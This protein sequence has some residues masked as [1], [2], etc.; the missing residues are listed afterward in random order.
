MLSPL[1]PALVT[2]L[3]QFTGWQLVAQVFVRSPV[4]ST[5]VEELSR[6]APVKMTTTNDVLVEVIHVQV[7]PAYPRNPQCPSPSRQLTRPFAFVVSHCGYLEKSLV[8]NI[9]F[10]FESLGMRVICTPDYGAEHHSVLRAL[11]N[12]Q[13]PQKS[14]QKETPRDFQGSG[15]QAF[16][17]RIR[18]R[19]NKMAPLPRMH[20][21]RDVI[22]KSLLRETGIVSTHR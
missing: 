6:A 3:G 7:L 20:I 12:T 1:L 15:L 5:V 21:A 16:G 18:F 22:A 11:W 8:S 9:P 2:V 14:S 13:S 19:H 4:G 17:I 10:E